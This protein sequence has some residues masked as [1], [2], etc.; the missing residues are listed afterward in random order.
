MHSGFV[1]VSMGK[2]ISIVHISLEF[3]IVLILYVT[4]IYDNLFHFHIT[5]IDRVHSNLHV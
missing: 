3:F 4:S 5:L 2:A 1:I